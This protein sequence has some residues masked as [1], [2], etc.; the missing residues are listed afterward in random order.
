[1]SDNEN[2]M[3]YLADIYQ[4]YD[5]NTPDIDSMKADRN[6]YL[7]TLGTAY[8]NADIGAL[9]LELITG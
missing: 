8:F 3:A 6:E 4:A 2:F 7:S 5:L 1:M 9:Y